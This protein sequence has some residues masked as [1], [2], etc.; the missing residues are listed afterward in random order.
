MLHIVYQSS[1]PSSF[2]EEEFSSFH[3]LFPYSSLW[4]PETGQILIQRALYEQTWQRSTWK[5]HI[6]NVKA[7]CLP[8]SERKN[9]EVGLLCSYVPSCDLQGRA[10]FDPRAI[11]WTN[12][13]EVH[14]EMLHTKYQSPTPSSFREEE[15]RSFPSFF[16]QVT[17]GTGSVLTQG[18]SYE[19]T[20]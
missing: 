19:Q 16:Q 11:I 9:F 5:C 7:P 18:A 4:F 1:M 8:V 10:N 12:M 20:W 2:K 17:P 15:F 14:K 6:P 3:S 13:V